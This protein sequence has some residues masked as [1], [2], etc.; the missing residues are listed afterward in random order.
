MTL[1]ENILMNM[2]VTLAK[3]NFWFIKK[4]KKD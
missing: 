1:Y 4:K 3:V 2:N